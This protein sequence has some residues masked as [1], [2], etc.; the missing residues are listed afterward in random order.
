MRFLVSG[1]Q[2]VKTKVTVSAPFAP[3]LSKSQ[4]TFFPFVS[5]LPPPVMRR[6]VNDTLKGRERTTAPAPEATRPS[7]QVLGN[8]DLGLNLKSQLLMCGDVR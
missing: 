4:I 3:P 5:F 6:R 2:N 7:L 8:F 1:P